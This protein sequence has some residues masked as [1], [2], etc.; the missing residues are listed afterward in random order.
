MPN[1]DKNSDDY[2]G[3]KAFL[4]GLGLGTIGYAILSIFAKPKC[5]NCKKEIKR[6]VSSCNFCGVELEWK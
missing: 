1:K 3:I 2:D 4:I 5:P 6:N